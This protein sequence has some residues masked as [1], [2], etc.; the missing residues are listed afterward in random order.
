[1]LPM[2]AS[3]C[4]IWAAV[5]AGSAGQPEIRAADVVGIDLSA[6]ML[7]RAAELTRD[8]AIR[9]RQGDLDGLAL[10]DEPFDLI[11]SSLALRHLPG[12]GAAVCGDPPAPWWL[13]AAWCSRW[14]TPS[15]SPAAARAGWWMQRD[16]APGPSTATRPEGKRISN[17]LADGVAKYHR[18][19]GTYQSLSPQDSRSAAWRSGGRRRRRLRPTRPWRRRRAPHAVAGVGVQTPGLTQ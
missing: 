6:K 12:G 16:A 14:S 13:A 18:T 19:L 3:G 11:Y 17:W 15:S 4:W 7:A 1:M 9:Y 2:P 5:M 10:S 8:E